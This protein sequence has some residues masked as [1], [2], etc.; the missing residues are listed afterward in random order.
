[1]IRVRMT[2][3]EFLVSPI[4]ENLGEVGEPINRGEHYRLGDL[5]R[6]ARK[7]LA[8]GELNGA[9][10]PVDMGVVLPKPVIPEDYVMVVKL[11][12]DQRD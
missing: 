1:M 4:G 2:G 7:F 10:M 8:S 12:N 3:R 5:D 11:S 6:V 9:S